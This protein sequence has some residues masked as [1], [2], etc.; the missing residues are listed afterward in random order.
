M[1][2]MKLIEAKT[3]SSSVAS[4]TFS[5]IPQ[6]YTD[7][8]LVMST[9]TTNAATREQIFI[10]P[11]GST[12]NNSR[13]VMY[14]YDNTTPAGGSGADNFIGWQNGGTSTAN[15]FS[16]IQVYFSNYTSTSGKPYF[17]DLVTE[18]NS[19]SA[20]ILNMNAST[21][22]N[23][24]AISSIQ[25][26]CETSTFASNSTFY[27]YGI[28]NTIASGAKATGGYVTEDANYFYHTFLSSGTF[29]PT[30]SLTCDYLVVAGGGGGCNG[31]GGAGGLRST[32]GATGGGGTLE[33]PLS[34]T[35]TAYAITVGAGGAGQAGNS[36]AGTNGS[37][38]VFSTI[39]STGGGGGGAQLSSSAQNGGNGGSGGGTG[40]GRPGP[41]GT[42]GTRTANQG[43]AGGQA[44][45]DQTTYTAGG[46]G[47][48]AGA[49]GADVDS[50]NGNG[51]NGGAGVAISALAI[52]TFTGRNNA[53]AGGG[54]GATAALQGKQQGIGGLG[55]GGN[56]ANSAINPGTANTGGGG[57][58]RNDS[59][60]AGGSGGS[61][62]V[63]IRYA[64]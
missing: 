57:G 51:A 28:S 59:V 1:D 36:Q 40:F 10:Y 19:S 14:G 54:A 38:S 25:I 48:G 46:G 20:Y 8:Q 18:N 31:G 11:N 9:R 64:K 17:A 53:Y 24:E 2:N 43:F 34:V 15:T 63:V 62:V 50:A 47:G 13:V 60:T 26:S 30:Q 44:Y 56:G 6:T 35:A 33:S 7:L 58:G 39:T 12:S 45:S 3:V 4:I 21:W 29:T 22:S 16:N 52:P 49:V 42:V 5:A 27:L 32:V 41:S 23:S 37:N 61:G 55:G